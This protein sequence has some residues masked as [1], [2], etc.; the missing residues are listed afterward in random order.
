MSQLHLLTEISF[1]NVHDSLIDDE[2]KKKSQHNNVHPEYI[3]LLEDEK[4]KVSY[5]YLV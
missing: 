2:K 4:F 5:A 1:V 3:R